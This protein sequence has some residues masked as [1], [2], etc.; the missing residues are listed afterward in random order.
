MA[1]QATPILEW[2]PIFFIF[3][4]IFFWSGVDYAKVAVCCR[5]HG[6]FFV[7]EKKFKGREIISANFVEIM[8]DFIHM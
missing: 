8:F 1:I 7:C 6:I 4:L 2:T 5:D 3:S